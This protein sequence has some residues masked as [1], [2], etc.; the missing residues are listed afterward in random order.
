LKNST[1]IGQRKGVV[2]LFALQSVGRIHT[3]ANNPWDTKCRKECM[4]IGRHK[5]NTAKKQ[6]NFHEQGNRL[7]RWRWTPLPPPSI[8][9]FPSSFS[10][11][12]HLIVKGGLSISAD[13]SFPPHFPRPFAANLF[14]FC[15]QIDLP[16]FLNFSVNKKL[17]I[18]HHIKWT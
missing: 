6:Q 15:P 5:G 14:L 2:W 8:F 4:G 13:L 1:S 3:Q 9:M 7:W 17:F 16:P 10:P 18:R 11:I 12:C